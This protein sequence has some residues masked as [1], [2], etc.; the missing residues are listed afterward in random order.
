[1]GR[2]LQN[3][4]FVLLLLAIGG[5]DYAHA[6][7]FT[8]S[9][10]NNLAWSTVLLPGSTI[11]A[12]CVAAQDSGNGQAAPS[13]KTDHSYEQG[14]INCAHLSL[15][16][17]YDPAQGA[18]TS[19]RYSY[20]A[21]HYTTSLGGVRYSPLV[22]QNN[23]YYY[24]APGD[25]VR[26]DSWVAFSDT[27]LTESRF[28]KL[29]GPSERQ[30][31]DFSCKGTRIQFGYVTRNHQSGND[32]IDTESGIDNW[33]ITIER[34][35]PCDVQPSPCP[36]NAPNPTTIDGEPYCC[37]ADVGAQT[38]EVCCQR[39]C[40]AGSVLTTINGV[41]FCCQPTAQGGICC[42]RIGPDLP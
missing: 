5:V 26:P 33:N 3:F 20:H 13:R 39:A 17:F 23:T 15:A 9:T 2:L 10:F 24:I 42:T 1:M 4:R 34:K 35:I 32:T 16:S 29:V 12:R 30:T 28:T 40:P 36:L 38:R 21:R 41:T 19:L 7:A 8:D 14:W 27:N 22:F 25:D 6:Q 11:N 37:S 18:I 31:P